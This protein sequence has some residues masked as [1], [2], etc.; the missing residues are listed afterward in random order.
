MAPSQSLSHKVTANGI[1]VTCKPDMRLTYI[2]QD[3][4]TIVLVGVDSLTGLIERL[5]VARDTISLNA[6]IE[7]LSADLS[8]AAR[9]K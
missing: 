2:Q 4:D 7:G 1:I 5:T 9:S 3:D 6:E 8:R